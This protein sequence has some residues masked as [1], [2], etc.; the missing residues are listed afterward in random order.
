MRVCLKLL[1][2]PIL[3]IMIIEA[4]KNMSDREFK[5]LK[6]LFVQLINKCEFYL[7]VL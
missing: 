7:R 5:K 3:T 1:R 2:R 4:T 6:K